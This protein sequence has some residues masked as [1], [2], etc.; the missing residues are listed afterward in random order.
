MSSDA[1]S[2]A[3]RENRKNTRIQLQHALRVVIASIGASVRYEMV[4][5]NVSVNGFFLDF[6]KPG[7][8]PFN[9]SSI[10]EVWLELEPGKTIFFN[11]KMARVVKKNTD[12]SDVGIGIAIKIVQIDKDNDQMLREFV[13]AKHAESE[14]NPPNVA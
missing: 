1:T 9:P 5:R 14:K 6:D 10:M 11:G 8:F 12:T 4:T 7:R 2:K 3:R 13:M